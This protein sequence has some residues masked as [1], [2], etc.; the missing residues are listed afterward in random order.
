M[1]AASQVGYYPEWVV[2]GWDQAGAASL[3]LAHH[4]PAAH[5]FG[6]FADNKVLPLLADPSYRTWLAGGGSSAGYPP[7][8][9][10][11]KLYRE[12]L[13]LAAGIQMAGPHLTAQSF[14]TALR[15]TAFPNPGAGADP[16]Y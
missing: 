9:G 15:H 4:A 1:K 12:M 5:S 10:A 14:A 13:L 3:T 8:F 2:A 7:R 6:V 16:S 11:Q